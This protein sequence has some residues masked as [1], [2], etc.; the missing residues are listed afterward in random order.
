MQRASISLQYK[1]LFILALNV[2]LQMFLMFWAQKTGLGFE[3]MTGLIVICNIGMLVYYWGAYKA[4]WPYLGTPVVDYL[5]LAILLYLLPLWGVCTFLLSHGSDSFAAI[6]EKNE[7]IISWITKLKFYNLPLNLS[8][9]QVKAEAGREAVIAYIFIL[10][11]Y[12]IVL[13]MLFSIFFLP[14]ISRG[15]SEMLAKH[16]RP[17]NFFLVSVFICVVMVLNFSHI[18][19]QQYLFSPGSFVVEF[20]RVKKSIMNQAC[21]AAAFPI[22]VSAIVG[23]FLSKCRSDKTGDKT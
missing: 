13:S 19:A 2:P 4:M 15:V 1:V 22:V 7:N 23:Y 5:V 17:L 21:T 9:S 16:P 18:I 6:A 20:Y 12:S 8:T 3:Y 11:K 10:T 14:Q